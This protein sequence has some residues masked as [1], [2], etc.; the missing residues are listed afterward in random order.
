MVWIADEQRGSLCSVGVVDVFLPSLAVPVIGNRWVVRLRLECI[1]TAELPS[2]TVK[3]SG[4]MTISGFLCSD[5]FGQ[6]V[7]QIGV[8]TER[9]SYPHEV[10]EYVLLPT[11]CSDTREAGDPSSWPVV[12][13]EKCSHLVLAGAESDEAPEKVRSRSSLLHLVIATLDDRDH[14]VCVGARWRF[15]GE[16]PAQIRESKI[17][18]GDI[19]LWDVRAIGSQTWKWLS[20]FRVSHWA[21]R[22]QCNGAAEPNSDDSTPSFLAWKAELSFEYL[23]GSGTRRAPLNRSP[24]GVA[25]HRFGRRSWCSRYSGVGALLERGSRLHFG[26]AGG[27]RRRAGS[28]GEKRTL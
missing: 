12:L 3:V 16:S 15:V 1:C 6:E 10:G 27:W 22:F 28:Y 25:V 11:G 20:G 8:G 14:D 9:C 5:T 4:R 7:P 23:S 19:T 13:R 26:P 24:L 18:K 21:V 2:W 17:E